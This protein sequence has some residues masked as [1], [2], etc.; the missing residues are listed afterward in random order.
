MT[1]V[2]VLSP[3]FAA[4]GAYPAVHEQAMQRL[5]ALG[6][7]PVEFPTTR[8]VGAC[9]V[10]RARDITAAF[11]DDSITAILASIGGDDQITVTRHLDTDIIRANPKPFLGYSDNTN[12]LNLLWQLGVPGF[13][14]GST[15]VQIG[16]GPYVEDYHLTSFL[17]AL[18]GAGE[19]EVTLPADSEDHGPV[20]DD[21]RALTEFGRRTPC[22]PLEWFGPQRIVEGRT[23]GG[24]LDVLAQLGIAGRFPGVGQLRGGILLLETSERLTP[25]DVVA[26]IVRALGEG[27]ILGAVDGVLLARTPTTSLGTDATLSRREQIDI[28]ADTVRRYN[29]DAV[30]CAGVPFG[31]T[32]PQW[33]L[34]YGGRVRLDGVDE[35]VVADY[36]FSGFMKA[37]VV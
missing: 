25:T 23:W 3:S 2:A 14:G 34:P 35:Q 1:R 27:G 15:Q 6:I 19:I 11:A 8:Q 22:D 13:Y 28:V 16:P 18:R 17:A 32:R 5:R 37:Q 4:P 7:E 10:D 9:P 21:P 24:C 29:P 36:S 33:I 30:M 20:W 31:H 12:L 26:D